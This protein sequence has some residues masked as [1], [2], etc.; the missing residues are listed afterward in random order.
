MSKANDKKYVKI[1]E[2]YFERLLEIVFE[3]MHRGLTFDKDNYNL[4]N[5]EA[6]DTA[7]AFI[8]YLIDN[9]V[10]LWDYAHNLARQALIHSYKPRGSG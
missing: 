1:E 8:D 3:D 9:E 10:E 6:D 5:T 2:G 4:S 7:K